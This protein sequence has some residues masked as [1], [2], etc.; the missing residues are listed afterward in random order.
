MCLK[1]KIEFENISI[2]YNNFQ[3]SSVDIFM[4]KISNN[5]Y[6]HIGVKI[7]ENS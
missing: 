4:Y 3:P 7:K 6:L 2:K 1:H 5:S